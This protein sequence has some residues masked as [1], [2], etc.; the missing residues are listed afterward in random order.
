MGLL[1][2]ALSF[3]RYRISADLPEPSGPF[4][5]QQLKTF[6]FQEISTGTEEKSLGWT[7]V[8]NLLDTDF[9]SVPYAY[10]NYLAFNLRIDRKT[11]PASLLKIKF[12]EAERKM[13][14]GGRTKWGK[15]QREE[16]KERVRLELLSQAHPSPSFFDICWAPAQK[17]LLFGA[18]AS[19]PANEFEDLFKRCFQ[20][21][22][23]PFL[24]WDPEV[25]EA[26][27][28]RKVK[29]IP[30]GAFMAP[31]EK[32]EPSDDLRFLGREFLT[33]LWFK[34]EERGGA[35]RV[36]NLGDL[37]MVFVRRLAL[38]SGDGEYSESVV[39]QGL[40]T[41]LKEGKA[42][43]RLG[44]KIKEARIQ[45]TK[46]TDKWEFTLKADAF[47]FQSL[48]LP[49]GTNEMDKDDPVG[50]LLERIFLVET[51]AK[52]MDQVFSLFLSRRISPQWT[53]EEIPKIRKWLDMK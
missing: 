28:A 53:G 8:E 10:G 39:C 32:G 44:K 38:E 49:E 14:K 18:L 30:K 7:S 46:D 4:I 43:I 45:L 50:H 23:T 40:H 48:R 35:V 21:P 12:M 47:Q 37:Q 3:S 5:D 15:A 31:Q 29:T 52:I 20:I 27:L 26:S 11:I 2:G 51:A 41:D 42:A 9:D 33:W 19:K 24:P 6:A 17:W 16:V 25:L 22:L 1:K 34:S 36:P 13:S